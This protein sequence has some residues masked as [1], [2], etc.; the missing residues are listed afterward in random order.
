MGDEPLHIIAIFSR[1]PVVAYL[2]DGR[3]IDLPRST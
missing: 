2:P 1:S 3:L